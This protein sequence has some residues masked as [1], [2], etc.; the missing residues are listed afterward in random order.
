MNKTMLTGIA[1]LAVGLTAA[2]GIG[3]WS[4]IPLFETV[5]EYSAELSD[6][7]ES[8]ETVIDTA[9]FDQDGF[10]DLFIWTI[11]GPN[12]RPVVL[13]NQSGKGFVEVWAAAYISGC[14]WTMESCRC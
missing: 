13:L 8:V 10:D 14:K 12:Y 1:G 11:R 4:G 9:D 2:V 5:E 3:A 6:N 7:Q